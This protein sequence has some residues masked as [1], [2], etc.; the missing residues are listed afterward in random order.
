M[1]F[2]Y[3]V[4]CCLFLCLILFVKRYF[5]IGGDAIVA[6]TFFYKGNPE[7]VLLCCARE[8]QYFNLC[9]L[10][11]LEDTYSHNLALRNI[12][13]PFNKWRS[14]LPLGRGAFLAGLRT[15]CSFT[16]MK[17]S[18]D[19]LF[20]ARKFLSKLSKLEPLWD[21]QSQL[22][23]KLFLPLSSKIKMFVNMLLEDYGAF[24]GRK[25]DCC[26]IGRDSN[27]RP[28]IYQSFGSGVMEKV[29]QVARGPRTLSSSKIS[30]IISTLDRPISRLNQLESMES[31]LKRNKLQSVCNA[32]SEAAMESL[33]SSTSE[34]ELDFLLLNSDGHALIWQNNKK[35]IETDD[36]YVD[37]SNEKMETVSMLKSKTSHLSLKDSFC[38]YI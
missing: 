38:E 8:G 20:V 7:C 32:L 23:T 24:E 29:N 17:S 11:E 21:G 34:V 31:F 37:N 15:D 19:L 13:R 14:I 12:A 3:S 26:I 16:E 10:C 4:H 33:G 36:R 25:F 9:D 28:C 1:F 6:K 22:D 5:G 2:R 18:G 35:I 30:S 27:N